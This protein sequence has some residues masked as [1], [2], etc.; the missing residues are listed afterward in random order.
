MTTIDPSMPKLI[1][2]Q[3]LYNLLQE[4]DS[5]K[6]RV[7]PLD[8][9]L[10]YP[11]ASEYT[12]HLDGRIPHAKFF[13]MKRYAAEDPDLRTVIMLPTAGKF[14]GVMRYLGIRRD[15]HIV[16]YDV[17]GFWTPARGAWMLKVFGHE[18]VSVLNG[19]LPAWKAAGY[20]IESGP[21]PA[22]TPS[23]YPLV[24]P[25]EEMIASFELMKSSSSGFNSG[26]SVVIDTR[27]IE[28]YADIGHFPNSFSL[29]FTNFLGGP[30]PNDMCVLPQDQWSE[31]LTKTV[32]EDL[33]KQMQD[34]NNGIQVI[35]TCG[36][37]VTACTL[38]M[39]LGY[40]GVNAI[41]SDESWEGYE[42]RAG[43][44]VEKGSPGNLHPGEPTKGVTSF[45]EL[46]IP[47][48]SLPDDG[49]PKVDE[50]SQ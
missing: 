44:P 5:S 4:Q 36:W 47:I 13:S 26:K 23:E 37:G 7:I 48:E 39:I 24:L 32:G 20:S 12:Q 29:P 1:S 16:C 18:K 34:K 25:N 50:V 43:N 21:Y 10:V 3:E 8:V 46:Q 6:P 49:T 19:G 35:S 17:M 22:A 27:P 30:P 40:F 14:V 33:F 11:P 41:V 28:E 31:I 42:M 45:P 38:W 2:P 9:S 15:D